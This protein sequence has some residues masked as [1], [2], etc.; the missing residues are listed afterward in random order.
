MARRLTGQELATAHH[1]TRGIPRG[2]SAQ[3]MQTSRME[4]DMINCRQS[5]KDNMG[6]C[7]NETSLCKVVFGK[8]FD[9][10]WHLPN[11]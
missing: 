7:S 8:A 11:F 9:Q 1:A 2:F 5:Q 6:N 3:H 4:T 10:C